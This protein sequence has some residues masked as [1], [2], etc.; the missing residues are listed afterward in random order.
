[1]NL[2]W[3]CAAAFALCVVNIR[4]AAAQT[5]EQQADK[6]FNE[7][8]ALAE[9]GK[10]ADACP[11]FEQ[12]QKLDPGVGT[13]F[14]LAD[15]YEH[16]GRLAAAYKMYREVANIA[17]ATGK[18]ERETLARQRAQALDARVP[19]LT[20]TTAQVTGT[21]GLVVRLDGDVQAADA[22]DK[23]QVVEAG[24]HTVDVSAPGKQPWSST[25]AVNDRAASVEIPGLTD[26][27]QAGG[28]R[29]LGGQRIAA[30]GVGA[31]GV[32]AVGV[33]AVFGALSITH[34]SSA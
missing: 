10:W 6:L 9:A 17:R 12:S 32:V 4:P 24:Q 25:V 15:C 23:A 26:T 30:I 11:K 5:P 22:L 8:K 34:N 14:N 33:G 21:P 28:S 27:P 16:I 29:P 3:T 31:A 20:I 2:R 13:E 1:M 18:S 19:R 7:G